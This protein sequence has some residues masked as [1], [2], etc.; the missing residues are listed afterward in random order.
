MTYYITHMPAY[1]SLF[2][3]AQIGLESAVFEKTT[4]LCP[5]GAQGLASCACFKPVISA[6]I[7]STLASYVEEE[8]S[9]FTPDDRV[10]EALEAFAEY[11]SAAAGDT[12]VSVTQSVTD[13]YPLARPTNTRDGPTNTGTAVPCEEDDEQEK[14]KDDGPGNRTAV[15]AGSITGGVI[16]SILMISFA[17]WYKI[18]QRRKQTAEMRQAAGGSTDPNP[19]H[20]SWYSQGATATEYDGRPVSE[21]PSQS[22]PSELYVDRSE[23][24]WQPQQQH[25]QQQQQPQQGQQ[26]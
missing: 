22:H 1:Q 21:L 19:D 4:W 15:L 5:E 17:V 13:A 6:L 2:G 7:T 16:F 14:C 24:G 25:Q 18:R 12:T 10:S 20:K 26:Y 9:D 3:C 23:W 11:C 8:C